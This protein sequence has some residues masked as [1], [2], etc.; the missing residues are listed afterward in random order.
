MR[1]IPKKILFIKNTYFRRTTERACIP[2]PTMVNLD[3]VM[4]LFYSVFHCYALYILCYCVQYIC[5]LLSSFIFFF[6]RK[7]LSVYIYICSGFIP[8]SYQKQRW[9]QNFYNWQKYPWTPISGLVFETS[10]TL[11][12]GDFPVYLGIKIKYNLCS[13]TEKKKTLF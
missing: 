6:L 12:N 3:W 11:Q 8:L 5:T 9:K 1:L 13:I 10:D 7:I 2:I 4:F